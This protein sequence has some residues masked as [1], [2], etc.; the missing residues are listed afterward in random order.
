MSAQTPVILIGGPTASGKTKLAVAIAARLGGEV[1][2]ADSMQVYRGLEILSAQPKSAERRD[3]PHH[4]FGVLDPAERGSAGWWAGEAA[5]LI[6]DIRARGRVPVFAGGTGL[7]FSALTEGLAEIPPASQAVRNRVAKLDD[8]GG[9]EAL[10]TEAERVDPAAAA[11]VKG[12]DRQRLRRVLEVIWTTGRPLSEWQAATVP[13]LLRDDWAGLVIE[14]DRDELRTCIAARF[15]LMLT[16]GALD[17]ARELM[18]RGLSADLPAMKALGVAP[19]FAQLRG[20]LTPEQARTHSITG[21]R[22]YAKRQLTWFRNRCADWPRLPG[23]D[24][25]AALTQ[26]SVAR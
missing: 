17:E 14:P 4:L 25:D 1:V 23:P 13:A 6:K 10:R 26:L 8:E 22:R 5:R 15:D 12:A 2:N 16:E 3:V 24:V 18:A 21:T 7:Y 11:K 19:L 9:S 20:E